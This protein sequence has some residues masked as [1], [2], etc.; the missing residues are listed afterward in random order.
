M[1]SAYAL[2]LEHLAIRE[3]LISENVLSKANQ[4]NSIK[5]FA[6]AVVFLLLNSKLLTK[7]KIEG[8]YVESGEFVRNLGFVYDYIQLCLKTIEKVLSA[9]HGS[10]LDS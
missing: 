3:T 4:S 10:I 5:T 7:K 9:D 6:S 8:S 2:S 1:I